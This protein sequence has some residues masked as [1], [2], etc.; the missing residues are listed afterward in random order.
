MTRSSRGPCV[1]AC[2]GVLGWVFMGSAA[3]AA[4]PSFNY[5]YV[6]NAETDFANRGW[7]DAN[8]LFQRNIRAAVEIWG[9]FIDSSATLE[10]DIRA[11]NNV[12][13]TGGT[14]SNGRSLGTDASGNSIFE[15]GPLSVIL[16]GSN[17]GGPPDLIF[18]V[19]SAFVDANYWLDPTP[20]DRTDQTPPIGKTDF[21]SI[22]L[23]E[24]G[25]GLGMAGTRQFAA[26]AGYGT[27]PGFVNPM[28]VLSY[29]GGD[30]NPLDPMGDPN[31][32]FFSGTIAAQVFGSDVPLSHAG[33]GEF[34]HSQDFYHLGTC[35]DVPTLTESLMNGCSVPTDGTIL[36]VTLL[37]FAVFRT[38]A[39][40]WRRSPCPCRHYRYGP[41]RFFHHYW[42]GAASG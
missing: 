33:P 34:F 6:D 24:L 41:R 18:S 10:M 14:F 20:E 9:G 3:Q 12:A 32:M 16:T 19:N 11:D 13:R 7:L 21:V 35:G 1:A 4:D 31:P 27:F 42:S 36:E 37:D 22:V 8:S 29:F 5:T 2:A 23:H 28:D 38:S 30:G 40:R 15:P 26:G 39:T 25:H 17:P